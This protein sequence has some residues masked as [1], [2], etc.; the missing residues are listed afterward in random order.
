MPI[1]GNLILFVSS[2]INCVDGQ[3]IFHCMI[4]IFML[5][6]NFAGQSV[7]FQ[8]ATTKKNAKSDLFSETSSVIVAIKYFKDWYLTMVQL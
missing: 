4:S 8:F 5:H 1:Q 7:F 6:T 2:F 3:S